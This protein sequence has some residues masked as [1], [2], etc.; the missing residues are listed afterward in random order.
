MWQIRNGDRISFWYDNWIENKNLIE[1][2][3]VDEA[4]IPNPH[5]KVS[6]F[7]QQDKI[8]NLTKLTCVLGNQ[9]I[10]NKIQGVVI[11][12]HIK[13]DSFCWGLN[14]LGSF[15]TQSATWLAHD[16]SINDST[17]WSY[18]WI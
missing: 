13:P 10:M 3:K 1:I 14:S 18:K 17:D 7:I 4:T 15:S 6:D 5:A 9:P 12:A 8:W 16:K 2:L 11:R